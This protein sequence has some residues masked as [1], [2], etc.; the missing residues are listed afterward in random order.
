MVTTLLIALLVAQDLPAQEAG[1][2]PAPPIMLPLQDGGIL[3]GTILAH[4]PEKLR[5]RRLETGG[6]LDLPWSYLDPAE[7][8]RMRLALGYVETEAEE[9]LVDAERLELSDGSVLVGHIESR[10]ESDLRLKRAESTLT[11]PLDRIR[12]PITS[13][14]VPALDVFTREELYQQKAFELQGR[15]ALSGRSGAE[16]HDQLARHA[17]RL[18][19]YARALEHYTRALELDPT[20]EGARLTQA[21]KRCQAKAALQEEVDALG[22]IDRFR[23]RKDYERA[24]AALADF[25]RRFPTSPLLEDWNRLKERVARAQERDLRAEIVERWHHWSLRL[26]QEAARKET[27]EEVLGYLDEKMS[28]DVLDKVRADVERIAPGILPDEVRRLWNE[29][30]GPAYR[31][32]SYGLGTWLLGEA[33]RAELDAKE[34]GKTQDPNAA[35]G[36]GTQAAARKKLEER[37]ARYLENQKLARA[38]AEQEGSGAEAPQTFWAGWTSAGR[39]QWILAYYAEKS[40]DFRDIQPRFSPCRECGGTGQ[41][42][43]LFTGSAIAGDKA[44]SVLIP[45]Q[46]CRTIG[47]VRR[48]RYR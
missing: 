16:A 41:R 18:L 26:A 7:A 13:V 5:F 15:L 35:P 43:V 8:Q 27:Y 33:A 38:A 48:I 19:D 11:I 9:L 4:D 17:E 45:C 14:Q 46:A 23:A 20:F 22:E 2:P 24:L 40:G 10:S 32:A 37:I 36:P 28:Q 47:I 25:P 21:I 34:Q 39:K 1:A 44:G 31:S 3:F 29:R 30:K 42:D 6:E 12:G